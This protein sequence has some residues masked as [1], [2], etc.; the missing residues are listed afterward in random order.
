MPAVGVAY[1]F[2]NIARFARKRFIEGHNTIDLLQQAESDREKEEITL[3]AMMDL[4]DTTVANMK[5]SCRH[6]DECNL[7]NCMQLI[8]K[9]VED[10]L[11]V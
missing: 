6:A 8:R 2:D 10:A 3:V 1:D 11:V 7:T 5:L 9:I 4:D